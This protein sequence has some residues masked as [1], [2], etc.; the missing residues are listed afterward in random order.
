M[1]RIC[2]VQSDISPNQT[3]KV[4]RKVQVSLR[5][6]SLVRIQY[7]EVRNKIGGTMSNYI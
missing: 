6:A 2:T 4:A 5:R 3:L 7:P 1:M